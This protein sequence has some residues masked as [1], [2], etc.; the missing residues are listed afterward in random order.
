[1]TDRMARSAMVLAL[2]CGLVGCDRPGPLS[3]AASRRLPPPPAAPGWAAPLAGQPLKAVFPSES[4]CLGFVDRATDRFK[5]ARRAVGWGWHLTAAR[6]VA[7]VVAVDAA[8]R[9]VGFGEGGI[10]RPDVPVAVPQVGS[11]KTGWVL[12]TPTAEKT[13]AIYGIDPAGRTACRIGDVQ[14]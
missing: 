10:D 7:Q 5:D 8:G 14:P 3:A 4:A 9:M 6:A 12:V 2:T 1:M 11:P 13:Y